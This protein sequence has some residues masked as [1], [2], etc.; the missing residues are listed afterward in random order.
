MD[1]MTAEISNSNFYQALPVTADTSSYRT[2]IV[3]EQAK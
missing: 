1:P 2:K 3:A